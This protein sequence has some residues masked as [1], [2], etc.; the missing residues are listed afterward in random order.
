MI[1]LLIVVNVVWYRSIYPDY[2]TVL[3][4]IDPKI[5][6]CNVHGRG[7]LLDHS[8]IHNPDNLVSKVKS[9]Y[10]AAVSQGLCCSP[11]SE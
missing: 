4:T 3:V 7:V 2:F 5:K 9:C 11:G 10:L 6:I 8:E 1:S